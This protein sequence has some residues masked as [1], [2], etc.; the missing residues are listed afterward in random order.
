MLP[1]TCPISRTRKALSL[2]GHRHQE[3][4]ALPSTCRDGLW[5]AKRG[6]C[7][8][9]RRRLVHQCSYVFRRCASA[10]GSLTIAMRQV[11]QTGADH[12]CRDTAT[13]A[14][15]PAPPGLITCISF[16]SWMRANAV[17][18]TLRLQ[19]MT[20]HQHS[21]MTIPT[22]SGRYSQY[23]IGGLHVPFA[24]GIQ[25]SST[26]LHRTS[27]LTTRPH[28]R[29][30]SLLLSVRDSYLTTASRARRGNA[31]HVTRAEGLSEQLASAFPRSSAEPH[32]GE[33]A[34]GGAD[35]TSDADT[36]MRCREAW[37]FHVWRR[38]A[39][40][41]VSTRV[42]RTTVRRGSRKLELEASAE[43]A[44]KARRLGAPIGT[45]HRHRPAPRPCDREPG[46]ARQA[47]ASVPRP[48]L[49]R[50][51][52][53]MLSCVVANRSA[54]A[55]SRFAWGESPSEFCAAVACPGVT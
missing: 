50:S 20:A 27:L 52:D 54:R 34:A 43:E 26:T 10:C 30:S 9:I 42:T 53:A 25:R 15:S 6:C 45:D 55:P 5:R 11:A 40:R 16:Y 4:H 23:L 7:L 49:A 36:G 48:S 39:K 33:R 12:E 2:S 51:R 21:T 19:Q 37:V 41:E 13:H 38:Y 35:R 46:Q 24:V 44:Q 3:Q 14:C 1:S 29:P 31:E 22:D 8:Y 18:S 47:R 28:A 17:A 32:H